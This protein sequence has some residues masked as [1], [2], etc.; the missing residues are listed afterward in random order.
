MEWVD[1][2]KEDTHREETPLKKRHIQSTDIY[3]KE[4]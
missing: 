4:E 1:I 3:K 2:W